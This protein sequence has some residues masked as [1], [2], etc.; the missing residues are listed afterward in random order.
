MW[1]FI[2]HVL[3]GGDYHHFGGTYCH[4]IPAT[5]SPTIPEDNN[6]IFSYGCFPFSYTLT[7]AICISMSCEHSVHIIV[8]L[9][10]MFKSRHIQKWHL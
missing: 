4:P 3:C 7:Y 1:S 2:Y 9:A 10:Y 6:H 5:P 8:I